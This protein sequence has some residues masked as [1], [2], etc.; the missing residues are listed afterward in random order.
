MYRRGFLNRDH[1]SENL[2]SDVKVWLTPDGC[3]PHQIAIILR[4]TTKGYVV[5]KLL[6]IPS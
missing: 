4:E 2:L 3:S 1:R 5:E 6:F